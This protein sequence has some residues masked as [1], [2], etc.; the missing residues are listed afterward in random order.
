M[1]CSGNKNANAY[2]KKAG[3]FGLHGISFD[4]ANTINAGM[5]YKYILN[6]MVCYDVLNKSL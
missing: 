3:F 1:G 5:P 4:G 2:Q 6:F